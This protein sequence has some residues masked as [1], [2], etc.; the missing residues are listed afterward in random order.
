MLEHPST[1]TLRGVSAYVYL[2]CLWL[3]A[4]S[5]ISEQKNSFGGKESK[6]GACGEMADTTDLIKN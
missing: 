2:L 1:L 6:N 3:W 4:F 5:G